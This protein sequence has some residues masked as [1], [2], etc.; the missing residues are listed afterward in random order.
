MAKIMKRRRFKSS[1]EAKTVELKSVGPIQMERSRRAKHINVSVR[2][3]K[4]VRVAVP[5][6]VSFASAELFAQSKAGWIKKQ[7]EKME[8]MERAARILKENNPIDRPT[9]C[10]QLVNRLNY[11]A[12]KH[13]FTYNRVF[14]RNQK[15]RWGSCSSR[16]NISLNDQLLFLPR[17]T[18][19]YLMVHELCHRRQLNHSRAFWKLVESHCP[20]YRAHDSLLGRSRNL[21]PDWFLLDLYS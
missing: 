9:A 7:V 3:Y 4:G 18:V 13:G 8:K 17:D 14:I 21:V 12:Q 20:D 2:P 11:L 19:E 10:K 16:G 15:T 5:V 6:G 1:V